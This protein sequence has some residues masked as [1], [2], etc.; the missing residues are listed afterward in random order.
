MSFDAVVLNHSLEHFAEPTLVL[1][2]IR[3]V[4]C[5]H[6]YLY[7]AV[8]DASTLTDRLYRWFAHG[9]G[10][11]NL[12]SDEE[13][14]V[15]L[16]EERTGLRHFATQ[17]LFS[18]FTFLNRQ[19]GS[20]GYGRRIFLVGG[21]PEWVLRM[22]TFVLRCIDR[23]FRS[24]LSL[25]GWAFYFGSSIA[26]DTAPRSNVCIRCGTGFSS[27]WLLVSGQVRRGFWGVRAF[28]CSTCGAK[29]FFT[30]DHAF[31]LSPTAS[32]RA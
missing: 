2:E 15:R 26:I 11:V 21:G 23:A 31:R 24:R 14:V 10:H 18:S 22:G 16:I 19:N 6:G 4:V 8:P 20:R 28:H 27:N 29:N 17:L 13:S 3:R 9:G 7:V 25:Y 32:A 30:D 1:S 12:F 5:H